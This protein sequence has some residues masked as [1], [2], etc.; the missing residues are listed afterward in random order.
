M[1][2]IDAKVKLGDVEKWTV[3]NKIKELH[4]FHMHQI[5]F[6]VTKI[7]GPTK[8]FEGLRDVIDVPYM[9]N[10]VPGEVEVVIPFDNPLIVGKFM[11]HC[12][13][14]EHGDN[15]MMAN[16]EVVK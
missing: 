14:A 10:G 7:Q 2:R 1:A 9:E 4:V 12:H 8:D 16:I 6:L 13:F 11:Y 5:D 3:I 15:G